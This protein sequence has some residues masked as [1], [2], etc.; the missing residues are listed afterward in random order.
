MTPE[1]SEFCTRSRGAPNEP[2]PPK[3]RRKNGSAERPPVALRHQP[4][5]ID[6]DHRGRGFLDH[7]REGHMYLAPRPWHRGCLRQ[8]RRC[9]KTHQEGCGQQFRLHSLTLTPI[10]L[11]RQNNGRF[12]PCNARSKTNDIQHPIHVLCRGRAGQG[13]EIELA[14][15]TMKRLDLRQLAQRAPDLDLAGAPLRKWSHRRECRS[16]RPDLRA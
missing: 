5:G 13:H 6:I 2:S 7:R 3:K 16:C 15:H 14:R 12:C 10:D 11:G 9:E 1:P 4:P 8:G